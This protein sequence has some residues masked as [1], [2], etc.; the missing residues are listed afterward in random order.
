VSRDNIRRKSEVVILLSEELG[1]AE[2]FVER[3]A[4]FSVESARL[5]GFFEVF[6]W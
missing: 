1:L 4:H 5:E 6:F 3:L 2:V